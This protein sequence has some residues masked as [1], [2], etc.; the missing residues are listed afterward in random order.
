MRSFAPLFPSYRE[1][2]PM[3]LVKAYNVRIK[4]KYANGLLKTRPTLIV[5][6]M[7]KITRFR[8]A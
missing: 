7:R 3:Q 2:T 5:H 1:I 8:N 4:S 6:K